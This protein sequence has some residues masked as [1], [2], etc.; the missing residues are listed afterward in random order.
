MLLAL[1]ALVFSF[2]LST[3]FWVETTGRVLSLGIKQHESPGSRFAN[4]GYGGGSHNKYGGKFY[5]AS[6]RYEYRVKD[7]AYEN[8]LICVCLPI[9]YQLPESRQSVTVYY[10]PFLPSVSVLIRGP[11]FFLS[12]LLLVFGL[13]AGAIVSKLKR[14]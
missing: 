11:H 10:L 8:S 2:S 3:I 1:A 14:L 5:W 7:E 13:G 6:A 9:G 4:A 12:G